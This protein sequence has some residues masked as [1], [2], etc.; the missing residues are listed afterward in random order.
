M[1]FK[2]I[3]LLSLTCISIFLQNIQTS[4]P[5]RIPHP[6]TQPNQQLASRL[7]NI[8]QTPNLDQITFLE[9]VLKNRL[10]I[11]KQCLA[12]NHTLINATDNNGLT[13]LHL[14]AQLGHPD[15]ALALIQASANINARDNYGKTPLHY[16]TANN[17][18]LKTEKILIDH[19]A[20]ITALDNSDTSP[21]HM[22]TNNHSLI[23]AWWQAVNLEDATFMDTNKMQHLLNYDQNLVNAMRTINQLSAL[24]I[25]AQK[26]NL[27]ATNM[28]LDN[29]ANIDHN[30]IRKNTP[31]QHAIGFQHQDIAKILIQ[32]NANVNA[33]NT[34]CV[35]IL[36]RATMGNDSELVQILLTKGAN[37]TT[38]DVNGTTAL[39]WAAHLNNK[40]II[41]DL[42]QHGALNTPD[43]NVKRPTDITLSQEIKN[44]I[45]EKL[46][47]AHSQQSLFGASL[48][49]MYQM[50][51]QGN[52]AP[53]VQALGGATPSNQPTM[54]HPIIINKARNFFDRLGILNTI[55]NKLNKLPGFI[56]PNNTSNSN[57]DSQQALQILNNPDIS[58]PTDVLH[59]AQNLIQLASP[60]T[61]K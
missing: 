29:N 39:H 16:A 56:I 31:L 54:M 34:D 48:K 42:I 28:L 50:Y 21:L 17:T 53:L 51:Q 3:L 4:N 25:A 32:A 14:A 47:E 35:S 30:D 26:G 43:N 60:T 58:L 13:A 40:Q 38:P 36:Q 20:D 59:Q 52:P 23:R 5:L 10:D 12:Q 33:K 45:I 55:I 2:Y 18:D 24:S 49:E 6:P 19:Y 44:W 46:I 11:V 7:S 37:V 9:A 15:M 57:L 41:K 61:Q 1:R 27:D 22:V 8:P